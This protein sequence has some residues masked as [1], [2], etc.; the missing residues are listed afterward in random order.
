MERRR[1]LEGKKNLHPDDYLSF[2]VTNG[3]ISFAFN[4]SKPSSSGSRNILEYSLDEGAS[5]TQLNNGTS[6][7]KIGPNETSGDTI[8][9][10]GECVTSNN[11]NNTDYND[12]NN[13]YSST[14]GTGIGTFTKN[15]DGNGGKFTVNGNI[16]SLIWK[17]NA[18]NKTTLLKNNSI[19]RHPFAGLFKGFEQL[20]RFKSE[21]PFVTLSISCYANMFEGCKNL[22]EAPNLPAKRYL[23]TNNTEVGGLATCC[24][25]N[26]FKGCTSLVNMPIISALTENN[27]NE[28]YNIVA[29]NCFL[30]MF[31][32]CTSLAEDLSNTSFTILL[33]NSSGTAPASPFKAMFK[34]CKNLTTTPIFPSTNSIVGVSCY[35]SMFE[36]CEKITNAPVLSALTLG[37]SAYKNMF[38]GCKLLATAP[39]LPAT[40]GIGLSSS[41]YEGMFEECLALQLPNDFTLGAPKVPDLGYFRMFYHCTSLILPSNFELPA[42]TLGDQ[43]YKEMFMNCI[44]LT[45]APKF[46]FESPQ[47]QRLR[48]TLTGSGNFYSMFSNCSALTTI[49]SLNAGS[50]NDNSTPYIPTNGCREMFLKCSNLNIDNNFVLNPDAQEVKDSGYY[51]MFDS[52]IK[53]TRAPELPAIAV[54]KSS[55]YKMFY[56]CDLLSSTPSNPLPA[57]ILSESCY[58][59]MFENCSNLTTISNSFLPATTYAKQCYLKMF[60]GCSALNNVPSDLLSS[61]QGKTLKESCFEYMFYN[62][63]ALTAAPQL[64]ATTLAHWC[65]RFMFAGCNNTNFQ[66]PSFPATV[67]AEACYYGTFS[68]TKV[69]PDCTHIHFNNVTQV[70]SKGF[71]GLFYGTRLADAKLQ[72]L[73]SEDGITGYELPVTDLGVECYKEMFYN[74]DLVVAPALPATTLVEGCYKGMFSSCKSLTTPPVLSSTTLAKS[75]YE[76]MFAGCNN[77]NFQAPSFP[78]T[79]LVSRC[80]Y[81]TFNGTNVYPDLTNINFNN[82]TQVNSGGFAGLFYGTK[83]NDTKLQEILT[84]M[85]INEYKLPVTELTFQP[86]SSDEG[87][88]CGMFYSTKLV[89]APTLSATT[90]AKGCYKEMFASC[91][92]LTTAPELPVTTLAN[93]CYYGMFRSCTSLINGPTLPATILQPSCYQLMFY[94]ASNVSS[95]TCL[96]TDISASQCT[97]QWFQ[98][99]TASGVFTKA[100]NMTSWPRN[101]VSGIPFGW[102]VQ[103]YQGS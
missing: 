5:W 60:S 102:T 17:D 73:L 95:V 44:A 55:Y 13:S 12:P 22:I 16:M 103:D 23:T 89:A 19:L 99:N 6:T 56:D 67:L 47:S 29:E 9:W 86:S 8:W 48:I 24:Y 87:C 61:S 51:R 100:A 46:P 74:T 7:P 18:A 43:G 38:K 33:R 14:Y 76:Q 4:G 93:D 49:Y 26:M 34:G 91:T 54:G 84:S 92:S 41:C 11:V 32:G 71:Q 42:L 96:A 59:S 101:S 77:T 2:K 40:Q 52:C 58:E 79:T 50:L 85:N 31:E 68:S 30:S 57:T 45:I 88:Y 64:P 53:L 20:E 80:Y 70:K 98:S 81:G 97:S 65:Y 37:S 69:L 72:E 66:A 75:C 94:Y 28:Q 1:L 25:S 15:L 83:L 21:L 27:E 3:F 39:L 35:E 36:G 82:S 62:C 10:R 78:A 90:L 63:T